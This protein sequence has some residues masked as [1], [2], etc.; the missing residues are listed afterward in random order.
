MSRRTRAIL[1]ILAVLLLA[2]IVPPYISLDRFKKQLVSTLSGALGRPVSIG[3][4]QLRLLPRPGFEMANFVV[5]D[6]PAFGAEPLLRADSVTADLRLSSLWRGRL[7]IGTLS[8]D[9]PSLNLVRNDARLWN[10]ESLLQ[11]ANQTPSAPTSKARPE[12]RP[13]F[14][15]IEA[16]TGRINFKFGN[17][18]KV[19]AVSD[20]DFSLWL[21]S[22]NEWRMRLEGRPVRTDVNLSDTGTLR[23]EGRFERRAGAADTPLDFS[24]ELADSQ[25]RE[26]VRLVSGTDHGWAGKLTADVKIMGTAS[27]FQVTAAG[28]FDDFRRYDIAG[29]EIMHFHPRCAAVY[30]WSAETLSDIDC[31]A[32]VGDGKLTASGTIAQVFGARR[33]DLAL[34]AQQVPA[35]DIVALVRHVKKDMAGDLR[36]GGTLDAS[37][38]LDSTPAGLVYTGRGL[39]RNIVLRSASLAPEL[40]VGNLQFGFLA[41]PPRTPVKRHAPLRA[42]APEPDAQQP[43]V[44]LPLEVPMGAA[45][46]L[47]LAAQATRAGYA[48]QVDGGAALPRLLDVARALGLRPPAVRARGNVNL[49]L[50]AASA[51]TGFRPPVFSGSL[52]LANVS[53][54]ISGVAAPLLV[55]AAQVELTP[56][57][58][59][60]SQVTARLDGTAIDGSLWLP[61]GCAHAGDCTVGFQL[62]ADRVDL[63]SLNRLLNPRL[64]PHPWYE[65]VTGRSPAETVSARLHMQGA[66]SIDRLAAKRLAAT[67][68][69]GTLSYVDGRL[70]VTDLSAGLLGGDAV[71]ATLH[72]D[73]GATPP[74]YRLEGDLVKLSVPQVAALTRDAWAAGTVSA[75]CNL[76]FAGWSAAEMLDSAQGAATL[77]WRGG[78]LRHVSLDGSGPLQIQRFAG[79]LILAHRSLTLAGAT[80]NAPRGTYEISGKAGF[81]RQVEFTLNGGKPGAFSIR[82]SVDAPRVQAVKNP[83]QTASKQE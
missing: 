76:I 63:D 48:L 37:L 62:H 53:A 5:G 16:S 3:D 40:P 9:N 51:W 26:L 15:Y 60:A 75:H 31:S 21:E 73:F 67:K 14:P 24:A 10:L 72:A 1:A 71:N 18:K 81:D 33:L 28:Q 35:D 82:G 79:R 7:E 25:L 27:R 4:I 56:Q 13:R 2:L 80:L 36:A 50:A 52:Q 32:P 8:L 49:Q 44:I 61:R 42:P 20:A 29:G 12:A 47:T 22:E 38:S 74:Q 43:F 39:A 70:D 30:T 46:P 69:S 41:P 66:F 23:V 11:R 19:W 77:D 58:V 55:N 6:D 57:Q 65:V 34:G 83:P 45:Q 68:V 64:Q 59:Q 54:E 17:E 78:A